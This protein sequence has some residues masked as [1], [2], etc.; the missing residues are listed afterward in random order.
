MYKL[1]IKN[2]VVNKFIDYYWAVVDA[3]VR[4]ENNIKDKEKKPLNH[5]LIAAMPVSAKHI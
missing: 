1:N 3:V 4:R 5:P 2:P